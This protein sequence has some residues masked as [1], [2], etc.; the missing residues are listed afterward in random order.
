MTPTE[1]QIDREIDAEKQPIQL[2]RGASI[3]G[4]VLA[5]LTALGMMV[6]ELGWEC[7]AEHAS[8]QIVNFELGNRHGEYAVFEFV[9]DGQA[10]RGKIHPLKGDRRP[11]VKI[12]DAVS[13]LY[14]SQN[15]SAF[16][17]DTIEARFWLPMFLCAALIPCLICYR[18]CSIENQ[19]LETVRVNRKSH[20]VH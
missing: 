3:C 2:L 9:V 11:N 7:S 5:I 20:L 16:V 17:R 18:L 12:G 10:Y 13:V 14:Q 8:A 4:G 1:D 19:R 6:Y 15:P